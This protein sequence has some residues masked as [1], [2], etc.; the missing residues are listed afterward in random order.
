MVWIWAVVFI[1]TLV[2]EIITVELASIWFAFGSFIAFILALCG[3][4]ETVQI[5]VF[6]VSSAVMFLSF[7]NICIKLLKNSKEKT[8]TDSLVGTVHKLTKEIKEDEPGEIKINDIPW[9]VVCKTNEKIEK[10][11]EVKIVEV[12]GNKFV[13]EKAESSQKPEENQPEQKGS[14]A[15]N[16]QNTEKPQND[17]KNE[18]TPK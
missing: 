17:L 11:C 14:P 2:V 10:N 16:D 7:R 3:V 1:V 5:V 9:R 4:N 15:E 12:Q 6:L 13:V 18:N 8:N